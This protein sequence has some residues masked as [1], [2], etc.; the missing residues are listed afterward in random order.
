VL[1]ISHLDEQRL[2]A[3][4][5]NVSHVVP[6]LHSMFAVDAPAGCGPHQNSFTTATGTDEAF[7][8]ALFAGGLLASTGLDLIEDDRFYSAVRTEWEH[9][10]RL[11]VEIVDAM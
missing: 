3:V 2:T 4:Q 7:Q 8:K 9:S 6:G 1:H 10:I 11:R 5:G